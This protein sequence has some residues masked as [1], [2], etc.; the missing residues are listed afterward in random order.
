MIDHRLILSVAWVVLTGAVEAGSA[1]TIEW[2]RCLSQKLAWYGGQEAGRIAD[3]VLLYQRG[4]GG[5]PKNVDMAR[6]LSEAERAKLRKDKSRT[7]STI[8]NSATYTQMRYLGKVSV[9]RPDDTGGKRLRDAFLKGLDYL[10]TAQ[11]PNGGWPQFYPNTKG[12]YGQIT[13]NDGAMV[14]VMSLLRDV[15][16]GTDDLAFVDGPRRVKAGRAV[17]RGVRCILKCQIRV[18]GKLTA[19]CAQHDVKSLRPCKA[20]SYELP[21]ISG[22]ESVGIVRFL[23]GIDNPSAEIVE[24]VQAAVAWFD[25]A[26]LTGIRQVT[27]PDPSAPGGKDKVIV[28][29]PAAGPLWGRFYEIGTNRPFFCSRDGVRRYSLAEIS[30]ER[31]N[32]YAWYVETPRSLLEKDYPKWQAKHVPGRN[33]L[34]AEVTGINVSGE[35]DNKAAAVCL[36]TDGSPATAARHGLGKLREALAARGAG[37]SFAASLGSP[38]V[39]RRDAVRGLPDNRDAPRRQGR[40]V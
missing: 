21:S 2:K 12:Y 11:H 38:A 31:R 20:R 29:D 25:G 35:A 13:F 39:S 7:D 18:G 37:V 9:A 40:P 19:W 1:G 16:D 22:H 17:A 4:T 28:A 3:N 15:S 33:V 30:H 27:K 32:G 34:A 23:M 10:L 8:D 26:K 24:A 14:G 36:V 5:W 6:V